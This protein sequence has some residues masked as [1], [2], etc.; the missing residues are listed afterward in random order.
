M[1]VF[2]SQISDKQFYFMAEPVSENIFRIVPTL[3]S[4]LYS[5]LIPFSKQ[6]YTLLKETVTHLFK[7][8]KASISVIISMLSQINESGIRYSIGVLQES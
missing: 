4:R 3:I 6:S 5:P 1:L 2:S 8:Y 7:V